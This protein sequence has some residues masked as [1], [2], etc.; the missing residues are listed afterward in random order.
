MGS[1]GIGT[2]R[3]Q[4]FHQLIVHIGIHISTVN[5]CEINSSKVEDATSFND[6]HSL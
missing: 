5:N 4:T 1:L 2:D 6:Y 3:N